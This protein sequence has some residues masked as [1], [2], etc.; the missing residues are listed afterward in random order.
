[1]ARTPRDS[2]RGQ[3][4]GSGCSLAFHQVLGAEGMTVR[5]IMIIKHSELLPKYVK[6]PVSQAAGLQ[7]QAP[8]TVFQLPSS[9]PWFQARFLVS[10]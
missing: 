6:E 4:P 8:R 3:G 1:M 10:L 2:P 9:L 5:N 7:S